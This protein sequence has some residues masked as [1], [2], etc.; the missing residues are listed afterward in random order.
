V[1]SL[2]QC[3][4]YRAWILGF[5]PNTRWT[6]AG[7]SVHTDPRTKDQAVAAAK[8]KIFRLR[9]MARISRASKR[10][11]CWVSSGCQALPC[12]PGFAITPHRLHTAALICWRTTGALRTIRQHSCMSHSRATRTPRDRW[13]RCA[14]CKTCALWHR[15]IASMAAIF[16]PKIAPDI[17]ALLV[18]W[19]F[20]S[21]SKWRRNRCP[22][23]PQ[24]DQRSR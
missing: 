16:I 6:S 9:S 22:T 18:L 5:G 14:L 15:V 23:S 1:H 4:Q 19:V 17:S 13:G 3:A 21:K 24:P 20:V 8:S 11:A 2:P 10:L 12:E 7:T